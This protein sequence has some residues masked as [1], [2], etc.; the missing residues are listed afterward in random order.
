MT[1]A[2]T[3]WLI[4]KKDVVTELRTREVVSTMGLFALLLVVVFAFAF[5]ID[6]SRSRLVAP[7]IVWVVILF[8]GTLGLARVFDRER[9]ND[10]LM[11]LCMAP[12]GPAAVYVGKALGVMI[13]TFVTEA[14]TLPLMLLF[15][16]VEVPTEGIGLFLAA[17]AL[18][19]AG[20]CLVGT[21]FAGMLAN[22]R[23]REVMLPLLVYPVTVP[24]IIA[25][26]ELTTIAF[27]GGLPQEA[28]GWL[29]LMVGFDILF[30]VVPPWIFG[31]VMVD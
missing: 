11:A 9:D 8:A 14:I 29:R 18:G 26:V 17:V 13:F 3:I 6:E 16:S 22:A 24:V 15:V 21:L 5:S 1:A 23:L 2:H 7:G 19:T 12:A 31:R 4:L 27:G 25:G 30:A 10:C 20:F 28:D